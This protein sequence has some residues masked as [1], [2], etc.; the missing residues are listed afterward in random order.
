MQPM[1]MTIYSTRR[2]I[3]ARTHANLLISGADYQSRQ[4]DHQ[5]TEF[6]D[7]VWED[8]YVGMNDFWTLG[9]LA[10]SRHQTLLLYA[11]TVDPLPTSRRAAVE[12]FLRTANHVVPVGRFEWVD[13]EN[14]IL[15]VIDTFN[16]DRATDGLKG[17]FEEIDDWVGKVTGPYLKATELM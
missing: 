3:V 6:Y 9:I 4:I 16:L 5:H 10:D 8:I 17:A 14:V 12:D 7:L 1:Q 11:R 13:R 15:Y 2:D